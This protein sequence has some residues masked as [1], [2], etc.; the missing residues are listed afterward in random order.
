LAGEGA[1]I[2]ELGG[3][4]RMVQ[5]PPMTRDRMTLEGGMIDASGP[6]DVG[7]IHTNRNGA[8]N[9]FSLTLSSTP[10]VLRVLP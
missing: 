8:L 10:N 4:G 3:G 6:G 5:P 1:P 2:R 9:T 7:N